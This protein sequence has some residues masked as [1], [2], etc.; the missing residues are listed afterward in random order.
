MHRDKRKQIRAATTSFLRNNCALARCSA[1]REWAPCSNLLLTINSGRESANFRS[2]RNRS[3]LGS[4]IEWRRRQCVPGCKWEG[5]GHDRIWISAVRTNCLFWRITQSRMLPR[6]V[7]MSANLWCWRVTGFPLGSLRWS[8]TQ[9]L[10]IQ[11]FKTKRQEK[12]HAQICFAKCWMRG[13]RIFSIYM[14]KGRQSRWRL[15]L[16]WKWLKSN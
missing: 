15:A 2:W 8:F 12:K 11:C 6:L 5:E 1:R 10:E 13:T 9:G 3:C 14:Q 4:H 7:Q 16:N